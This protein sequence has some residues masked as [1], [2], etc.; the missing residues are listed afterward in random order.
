MTNDITENPDLTAGEHVAEVNG[1]AL[2]YTV[3]G[4]GPVLLFPSPG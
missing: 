4:S 3:Q 1:F 2:H